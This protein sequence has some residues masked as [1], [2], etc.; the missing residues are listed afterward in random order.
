MQVIM[1]NQNKEKLCQLIDGD[2]L[3][4]NISKKIVSSKEDGIVEQTEKMIE[5][6]N[7]YENFNKS[8]NLLVLILWAGWFCIKTIS[9]MLDGIK[10]DLSYLT[11]SLIILVGY[12]AI[13]NSLYG[14]YVWLT[15]K[16]M[17]LKDKENEKFLDISLNEIDYLNDLL[18]NEK[19]IYESY[20][21]IK[22]I[23]RKVYYYKGDQL[24]MEGCL[25]PVSE[26]KE[27]VYCRSYQL[28]GVISRDKTVLYKLVCSISEPEVK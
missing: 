11:D 5:Q 19:E 9:R 22:N 28:N 18:R 3:A 27:V 7:I 23:G 12:M 16:K 8:A 4:M 20:P 21:I 26:A 25:K 10:L 1:E 14:L 15:D 2:E 24:M 17:S 13:L 6:K